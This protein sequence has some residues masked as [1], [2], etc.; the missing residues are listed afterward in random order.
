MGRGK[1][2]NGEEGRMQEYRREWKGN[3]IGWNGMKKKGIERKWIG[4]EWNG[5]KKEWS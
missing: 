1:E 2:N 3:G 4:M 5:K